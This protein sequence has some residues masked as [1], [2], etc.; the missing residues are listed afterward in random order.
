MA[1]FLRLP[2]TALP[3]TSRRQETS[4]IHSKWASLC[5]GYQFQIT[6]RKRTRRERE[7]EKSATLENFNRNEKLSKLFWTCCCCCCIWYKVVLFKFFHQLVGARIDRS[8]GKKSQ[9]FVGK[10]IHEGGRP[11]TL[12]WIDKSSCFSFWVFS[13]RG[14]RVD[15]RGRWHVEG[16]IEGKKPLRVRPG[17]IGG[18]LDWNANDI[19]E[20]WLYGGCQRSTRV[21]YHVNCSL[22]K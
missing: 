16:G 1:Q 20:S 22:Y 15:D 11:P 18:P 12:S 14:H 10:L 9:R 3:L 13:F 7:R 4:S 8:L 5:L 19:M 21:L 2:Y 17:Q 6:G